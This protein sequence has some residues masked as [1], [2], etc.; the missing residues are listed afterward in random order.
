M[1]TTCHLILAIAVFMRK[2]NCQQDLIARFSYINVDGVR[3][4]SNVTPISSVF[5]SNSLS[6]MYLCTAN[7]NCVLVVF[8]KADNNCSFY[9]SSA[10]ARTV[11]SLALILFLKQTNR[12]VIF[13]CSIDARSLVKFFYIYSGSEL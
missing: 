2:I 4:A 8:R 6:C 5:F 1:Q 7:S 9:N 10:Q 3:I 11:S 13:F 12:Q